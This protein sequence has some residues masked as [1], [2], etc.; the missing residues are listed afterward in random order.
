MPLGP[1]GEGR[2]TSTAGTGPGL[3]GSREDLERGGCEELGAEGGEE[4]E[5]VKG[6]ALGQRAQVLH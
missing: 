4:E 6:G 3:N 2:C 5:V 1:G